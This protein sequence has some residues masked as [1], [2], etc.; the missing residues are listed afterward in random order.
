VF[1]GLLLPLKPAAQTL[2]AWPFVTASFGLGAFGLTP[3]L[4]LTSYAPGPTDAESGGARFFGS[5]AMGA[6]L[7]ATTVGLLLFALG[8][9]APNDLNGGSD[10][11]VDVIF[12]TYLK[13]FLELF[14][15]YK[16]VHVPSCDFLALWALSSTPLLEDMR[17]RGWFRG[18]PLD[19]ALYA[20]FMLAPLLGACAWLAV[21]PPLPAAP[22]PPAAPVDSPAPEP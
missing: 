12:Y 20:S 19:T 7:L 22:A 14:R 10:Y 17:R 13:N 15:Q 11:P 18:G 3:Y 9:F 8:L 1:A 5:P 4:A 2:P 6:A 16:L 21:R